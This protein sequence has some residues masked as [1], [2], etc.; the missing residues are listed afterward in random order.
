MK[1]LNSEQT[2]HHLIEYKSLIE[3]I[4]FDRFRFGFTLLLEARLSAL[5]R[6][7][8]SKIS[9]E[10]DLIQ[11]SFDVPCAPILNTVST[12]LALPCRTRVT[13]L[14]ISSISSMM[15]SVTISDTPLRNSD[16][17]RNFPP[18]CVRPIGLI[19]N[20]SLKFE[21]F[22]SLNPADEKSEFC[23]DAFGKKLGL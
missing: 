23:D 10:D 3:L 21:E 4:D 6:S 11:M 15:T 18:F 1:T 22:R 13:G 7:R 2:L 8:I 19:T 16:V 9:E 5:T 14:G 17:R 20:V 12:D